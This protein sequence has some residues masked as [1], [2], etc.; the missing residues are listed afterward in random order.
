MELKQQWEERRIFAIFFLN[1][2]SLAEKFAAAAS[3]HVNFMRI[4]ENT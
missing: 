2:H 1:G 4:H 3:F